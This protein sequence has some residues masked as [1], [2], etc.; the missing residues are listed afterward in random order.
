MIFKFYFYT[1]CEKLI[2]NIQN[3]L[4]LLSI[5]KLIGNVCRPLTW[6]LWLLDF[7]LYDSLTVTLKANT[8]TNHVC[9][10]T[11]SSFIELSFFLPAFIY[12]YWNKLTAWT[13]ANFGL[14][15]ILNNISKERTLNILLFWNFH[16]VKKW[17]SNNVLFCFDTNT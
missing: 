1:R 13:A 12:L 2:F 15:Y 7:I 8:L 5:R 10:S 3:N 4:D 11:Q 14:R 16:A 6:N 17:Y 9:V